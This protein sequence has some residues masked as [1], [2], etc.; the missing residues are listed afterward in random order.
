M[1]I[2]IMSEVWLT[3]TLGIVNGELVKSTKRQVR[4]FENNDKVSLEIIFKKD[5]ASVFAFRAFRDILSN[6]TKSEI[7]KLGFEEVDFNAEIPSL[8]IQLKAI[9]ISIDFK[10]SHTMKVEDWEKVFA[11]L[12]ERDNARGI[13][14]I[15]IVNEQV[16]PKPSVSIEPLNDDFYLQ[17]DFTLAFRLASH[18]VKS[19]GHLNIFATGPS[20]YGKTSFFQ[21]LAKEN[22]IPIL[23]MNCPTILDPE[24]WFGRVQA[25]DGNTFFEEKEW[26]GS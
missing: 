18:T 25:K 24:K 12:I 7:E 2:E 17:D 20:G 15:A 26:E 5:N 8:L 16:A 3:H 10:F 19:G 11:Q 21:Y 4:Q 1:K 22:D 23:H 6:L 9:L 14:N 13:E